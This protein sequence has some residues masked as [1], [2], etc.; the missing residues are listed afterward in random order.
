[1]KTLYC[2]VAV[3]AALIFIL[4]LLEIQQMSTNKLL[5]RQ[6]IWASQCAQYAA[7]RAVLADDRTDARRKQEGMLTLSPAQD[8]YKIIDAQDEV[9]GNKCR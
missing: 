2:I 8:R 9:E 6:M 3:Q 4:I 7:S 5:G 1:M